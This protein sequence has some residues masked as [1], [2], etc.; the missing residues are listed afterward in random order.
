MVDTQELTFITNRFVVPPHRKQDW[1]LV[2]KSQFTRDTKLSNVPDDYHV[3][4]FLAKEKNG[5]RYFICV[6]VFDENKNFVWSHTYE[7][8]ENEVIYSEEEVKKIEERKR[9]HGN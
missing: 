3:D 1:L 7:I 6:H 8:P 9:K 2:S 4:V 5:E